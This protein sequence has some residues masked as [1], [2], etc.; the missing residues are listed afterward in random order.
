MKHMII[1]VGL[2]GA[3]KST[4]CKQ[5][6]EYVRISQ[7]EQGK[8]GCHKLFEQSVK[9][10]KNI[11]VDRC[12]FNLKQR[13]RYLIPGREFGYRTTIIWLQAKPEECIKRIGKRIDHPNLSA[14]K[15]PEK[16]EQVVNMF[17]N[18]FEAPTLDECDEV[19]YL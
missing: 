5:Y 3:G 15:S 14:E 13:N 18:M 16:I 2:P 7:D 8:E 6:P 1:L 17:Y 4:V 9:E 12:N 11:I 19:I 10:Q